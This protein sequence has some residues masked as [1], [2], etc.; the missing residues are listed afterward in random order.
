M[1]WNIL[2][3]ILWKILREILWKIP[4]EI[5]WKILREILHL[6][7][8]ASD[9]GRCRHV[10]P[11]DHIW[12]IPGTPDP[13]QKAA[14]DQ[15]RPQRRR[16]YRAAEPQRRHRARE[17]ARRAHTVPAGMG[18]KVSRA[19]DGMGLFPKGTRR[20]DRNCH[21]ETPKPVKCERCGWGINIRGVTGLR[22]S[23]QHQRS[24]LGVPAMAAIPSVHNGITFA[25]RRVF[26]LAGGRDP[27]V[28]RARRPRAPVA[29]VLRAARASRRRP[30][31]EH[32]G[33]GR[34]N[35]DR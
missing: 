3:E 15:G 5:L 2:R 27:S 10:S 18:G 16:R 29:A 13:I 12:R 23:G 20:R 26:L 17:P 35:D 22:P 1:L 11:V 7:G 9:C 31:H 30:R 34:S 24:K 21:S 25:V 6:A 33:N 28:A 4:R 32:T 19:A 14:I 8:A